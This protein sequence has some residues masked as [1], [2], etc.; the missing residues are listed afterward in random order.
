MAFNNDVLKDGEE[1]F[2]PAT[3]AITASAMTDLI[4]GA[5]EF[6]NSSKVVLDEANTTYVQKQQIEQL[7]D[8]RSSSNFTSSTSAALATLSS[9]SSA[10]DANNVKGAA[11]IGEGV[12]EAAPVASVIDATANVASNG[13]GTGMK[14]MFGS[15]ASNKPLITAFFKKI[16]DQKPGKISFDKGNMKDLA[17]CFSAIFEKFTTSYEYCDGAI[18]EIIQNGDS[19]G[20]HSDNYGTG[21]RK[22]W[23]D[24]A[25]TYKDFATIAKNWVDLII[26]TCNK[27]VDAINEVMDVYGKAIDS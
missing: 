25:D 26:M 22:L 27:N 8:R 20:V 2:N 5:K 9:M 15:S 12:G 7:N 3:G 10:Y 14:A 23:E 19:S 17:E 6:Y 24:N 11:A 1:Y 21:L 16:E 18:K 13:S 4:S